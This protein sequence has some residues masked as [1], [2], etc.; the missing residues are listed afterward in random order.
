MHDYPKEKQENAVSMAKVPLIILA[1]VLIGFV[2]Y[3]INHYMTDRYSVHGD[4]LLKAAFDEDLDSVKEL[5]Q[6]GNIS[7]D[8]DEWIHFKL[9][10]E[11][12]L[13]EMDTFKGDDPKEGA[14]RWF[15]EKFPESKG[16]DSSQRPN[17][18]FWSKVDST[19]K[20]LTRQWYMYNW[21]TDDHYY[22]IFGM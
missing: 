6:G 8:Y 17:L 13:K 1:L 7:S 14:R 5:S 22:R 2:V 11:A 18:K 10:R 16:L 19:Q 12:K 15:E 21:R 3:S 4:R 9:A 20:Q